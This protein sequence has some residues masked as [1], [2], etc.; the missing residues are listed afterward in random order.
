MNKNNNKANQN[1]MVVN[2]NMTAEHQLK[3]FKLRT[4]APMYAPK[5]KPQH[6]SK[7]PTY[8]WAKNIYVD[9]NDQ[10]V[11]YDY[12]LLQ[13]NKIFKKVVDYHPYQ[14]EWKRYTNKGLQ[15]INCGVPCGKLNNITVVDLDFYK[16]GEEDGNINLFNKEFGS[17][18]NVFNTYTVRT[19][20]GGWH[21]YFKFNPLIKQTADKDT[22]VDIRSTGG[23]VVAAGTHFTTDVGEVRAYTVENDCAIATMPENLE[24]WLL[25]NIYKGTT[26]KSKKQKRN[27]IVKVTN[28]I[29]KV[30]EE[31]EYDKINL[32]VYKYNLSDNDIEKYLCEGLPD[33]FFNDREHHI[34]FATGMKTLNKYDLFIKWS[35]KRCY[36]NEEYELYEA[37][38][39]FL[40]VVWNYITKHNELYCLDH[41]GI[42][43]ETE[44]ANAVLGYTKYKP[45]ECHKE[46]ATINI[47]RQKLGYGFVEEFAGDNKCVVARSD[48]GTGKTTSMKHYLKNNNKPFIS[49][50][51][52]ISLG[53]EQQK[54]FYS[55]GI[56]CRYWEQIQKDLEEKNENRH[57]D[58]QLKWDSVEG[59]N[60]VIT[61]DSLMKL[62]AFENFEGYTIYL[63]EFNSLI[64]YLITC[65]NM[66]NKRV[67]IYNLLKKLLKQCELIVCSD[68]DI[69]D[70]SL[71]LLKNWN[72]NYL[73]INNKYKHNNGVKAT[74]INKFDD[75]MDKLNLESKW[76]CCADSKTI[77]DIVKRLHKKCKVYTSDH[78]GDIDLDADDCVI[79]SPKIVYGLDSVMTRP[80]F[81]YYK[82]M[83]ITPAAM[84]QQVARNRN[85]TELFFHFEEFG[86]LVSPYK[87]ETVED[88]K[89]DIIARDK[90]GSDLFRSIDT[91]LAD[92]YINLLAGFEYNYDCYDTNKFGHFMNIIQSRGF[93]CDMK[94]Q[95]TVYSEKL[96]ELAMEERK[97]KASDIKALCNNYRKEMLNE[98]KKYID[99]YHEEINKYEF[100][101]ELPFAPEKC[102]DKLENAQDCLK[103]LTTDQYDK[104]CPPTDNFP[105]WMIRKNEILKIPYT[106]IGNKVIYWTDPNA[107]PKH[108]SVCDMF[109]QENEKVTSELFSKDDFN[110]QKT[111]SDK[112]KVMLCN[113][114]KKM[115]G[116]KEGYLE[117]PLIDGFI[118]ESKLKALDKKTAGLFQKEYTTVFRYRGKDFVDLTNTHECMVFY[119]KMTGSICG[120][121][122]NRT[123]IAGDKE[124]DIPAS[125]KYKYNVEV[126]KNHQDLLSYRKNS[127]DTTEH[128][129]YYEENKPKYKSKGIAQKQKHIT[130]I[131]KNRIPK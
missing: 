88:C 63:D 119:A 81:C 27:P 6:Y 42:H 74:E 7:L 58:N 2:Y 1:N 77:A 79:F 114:F 45:T 55:E 43:S 84:V 78:T 25:N 35:L 34:K 59:S 39:D 109:F 65:G 103:S 62:S 36:K 32:G 98:N 15:N 91:K 50:V 8:Q 30:E 105:E 80:V 54:V 17:D 100:L 112:S 57:W 68:A 9:E 3:C 76:L 11:P 117:T 12:K 72:I 31:M 94:P 21:L 44:G 130:T 5:M 116:L 101:T 16:D 13:E 82:G 99:D 108:I 28:P 23:Y 33:Y 75:F 66:G 86:K 129:K 102:Y 113:K 127:F 26:N 111:T 118:D 48:T 67:G 64:E 69:S 123:V 37:T 49:I 85:I 29:T 95:N 10:A 96:K 18:Y 97:A 89:N 22:N 61:I 46:Q 92:E 47:D 71:L 83:T 60:I 14:P 20:S 19:G 52:R 53:K 4:T 106:D 131:Q 121:V 24:T 51:S 128:D 120:G 126:I 70:N 124:K 110:A 41:L 73:Y 125:C 115:I 56:E 40:K 93:I 90:Y 107:L 38:E 104:D 87:Y 122:L